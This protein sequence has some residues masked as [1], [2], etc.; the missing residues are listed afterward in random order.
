LSDGTEVPCP[1]CGAQVKLPEAHRALHAADVARAL[2]DREL[3]AHFARLARPPGPLLRGWAILTRFLLGTTQRLATWLGWAWLGVVGLL[4]RLGEEFSRGFV[5]LSAFAALIL[6]ATGV[7]AVGSFTE[8]H[9]GLDIWSV[10][11]TWLVLGS[12]GGVVSSL[13]IVP[14]PLV[15]Y[16]DAFKEAREQ[17]QACLAARPPSLPGGP[18]LCRHCGAALSVMPGARGA[19]CIYCSTDNL[20]VLD[21]N[22]A[23]QVSGSE[24][25]R[26]RRVADAIAEER[27]VRK[28]AL[29][30]AWTKGGKWAIAVPLIAAF[31]G[32]VLQVFVPT[33]FPTGWWTHRGQTR[34]MVQPGCAPFDSECEPG[35][36]EDLLVALTRGETAELVEL[37]PSQSPQ[38]SELQ[39]CHPTGG[40]VPSLDTGKGPPRKLRFRADAS[41]W[42]VVAHAG[43]PSGW[44]L[45]ITG[46]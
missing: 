19:R 22:M 30:E 31:L 13:F 10:F 39:A 27:R 11:P 17:A 18:S 16:L 3:A 1:L 24:Q 43:H 36:S 38:N 45:S 25:R 32:G 28:E 33:V 40:C 4:G 8:R 23:R 35:R 5:L 15:S 44:K 2:A 41:G 7:S 46:P 20:L 42:Y 29:H 12:I 26:W 6:I 14:R 34:P 37:R 21:I 9:L